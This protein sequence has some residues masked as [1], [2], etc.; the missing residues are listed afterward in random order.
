MSG[1]TRRASLTAKIVTAIA[2]LAVTLIAVEVAFRGLGIRGEY[3]PPRVRRRIAQYP[4]E[5]RSTRK[6]PRQFSGASQSHLTPET[7]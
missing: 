5:R 3:W 1:L 7:R 2:S 4:S 6:T